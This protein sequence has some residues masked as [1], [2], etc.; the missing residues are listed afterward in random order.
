M[1]VFKTLAI[2][3]AALVAGSATALPAQCR[4]CAQPT[5][6]A[7]ALD[8]DDG[9]T[10][11]IETSLNFDRLVLSAAGQG[12]ALVRPDGSSQAQGS[13]AA[14]SGRAMVGTAKVHGTAGRAVRVELPSRID[15]YSTSGGRIGLDELT[16][17]LPEIPKL[18]G[19]GNL[20]FHFGGRVTVTGDADG[21]Y[22]GEMPITVDY[23]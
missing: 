22:R 6:S 3:A 20:S 8:A 4:L 2:A 18:D 11:D 10:I 5:T 15:L 21:N 19:A 17:D 9:L 1:R 23:Q 7:S 16:T 14:V 12:A 13:I